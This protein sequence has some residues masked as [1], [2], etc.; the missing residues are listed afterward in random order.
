MKYIDCPLCGCNKVNL[1]FKTKNNSPVFSIFSCG[2]CHNAWTHPSPSRIDYQSNDFHANT[3]RLD[4][5]RSVQTIDDL[6]D[7]WKKS[8]IMQVS[9]LRRTLLPKAKILEIGCGEGL[10]LDKLCNEGFQVQGI[11]PSITGSQRGKSKG[12]DIINGYFPNQLLN[13]MFDA[14]V[15]SH[16]LE[17]CEDPVN[18]LKEITKLLSP[19][20]YLL[21][22]QTNY[23]GAIPFLMKEKW[24]AW[25]PKEHYWHFTPHGLNFLA[26]NIGFKMIECEFSSLVHW[27]RKNK[28]LQNISRI[29][30]SSQDQF[31]LLLQHQ[32][33]F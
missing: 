24:Y 17:H 5:D 10:L 18:I 33:F 8:I 11:E 27:G 19:N 30:P 28:I 2:I 14:V 13:G 6:P 23:K 12:L 20:G 7:E 22:I 21:L 3:S 1:L 32:S 16:V 29:F 31:H 9:L 15:I 4:E 26:K 25:V